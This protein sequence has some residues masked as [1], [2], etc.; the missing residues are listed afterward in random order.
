MVFSIE[1]KKKLRDSHKWHIPWNKW[2]KMSDEARLNMS[3]S[4]RWRRSPMLWIKRWPM[5]EQQKQKISKSNKLVIHTQE[6][7]SRV[8]IANIGKKRS[9]EVKN[10]LSESHKWYIMP[11]EQKQKIREKLIWEL[12]SNW[13][14]WIS[15][16]PYSIGWTRKFKKKIR[17]RDEFT[18]Q[19]CWEKKWWAS[20]PIHHIDYNKLNCNDSNLVTLCR[21]CHAKTNHNRA[22][23]I[24]FFTS[25]K[26][27]TSIT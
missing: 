25:L 16:L 10:K 15:S 7:N 19:V 20:Y 8:W 3:I 21:C 22:S 23:W 17:E 6:W 12:G 5:S 4:Q 14:W 24:V 26:Y 1:H 2:I 9:E 18:C 11:E 13:Q 27:N